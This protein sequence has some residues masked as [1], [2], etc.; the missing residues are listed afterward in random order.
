MQVFQDLHGQY[1]TIAI[2]SKMH[3]SYE[4]LR[5]VLRGWGESQEKRA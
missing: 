5:A 3:K 1:K 4:G 2:C